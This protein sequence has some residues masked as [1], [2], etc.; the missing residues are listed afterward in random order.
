MDP[1]CPNCR[2]TDL[3]KVS[4][5]YQEGVSHLQGHSRLRGFVFGGGGGPLFVAG[6]ATISGIQRTELSKMLEPPVK[7]S[8]TRLF[9]RAVAV[10]VVAIAAGVVFVASSTPPVSTLPI[11][12]YVFIAPVIFLFLT[13][14]VWR[15][16][17]LEYPLAYARWNRS[18][19][20]QRCGTVSVHDSRLPGAA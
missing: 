13:F 4:L 9:V 11:K 5:A 15:Y 8:Y 14:L 2:S 17:R 10:T 19:V 7:W 3:K 1:Q 6:R 18:Y 16:N 20:C 12:L